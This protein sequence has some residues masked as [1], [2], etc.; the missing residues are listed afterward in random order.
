MTRGTFLKKRQAAFIIDDEG[1]VELAF[2]AM[3]PD[4][5]FPSP[6]LVIVA[7]AKLSTAPG[8]IGEMIE[9]AHRL[10]TSEPAPNG[11]VRDLDEEDQQNQEPK[12]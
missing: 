2:P 11:Q 10:A 9:M 6:Y 3:K 1:N 7:L 4:E 12:N 5:D 8:W